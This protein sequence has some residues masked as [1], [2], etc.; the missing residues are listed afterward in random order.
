[1]YHDKVR[2]KVRRRVLI[3]GASIRQIVRETGISRNTIRTILHTEVC[4]VDLVPLRIIRKPRSSIQTLEHSQAKDAAF[5]WMRSI[6]QNEIKPDALIHQVGGDLHDLEEL[7][8]QL[9][10]GTLA[11]R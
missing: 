1:M 11:D 6:L 8:R 5:E 10:D 2:V 7:L 4:K 9:Y 3:D